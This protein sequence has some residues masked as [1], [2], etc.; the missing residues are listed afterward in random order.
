M[1]PAIGSVAMSTDI[2]TESVVP[3]PITE[4]VD[5]FNPA[6]SSRPA[7]IHKVINRLWTGYPQTR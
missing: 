1:S 6:A 3:I 4:T 7:V 2:V 5:N